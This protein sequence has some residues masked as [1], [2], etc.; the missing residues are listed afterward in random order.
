MGDR[1][2]KEPPES[3]LTVKGSDSMQHIYS[4]YMRN[5]LFFL[6]MKLS[7]SNSACDSKITKEIYLK[8]RCIEYVCHK[9]GLA[10]LIDSCY[11]R[12]IDYNKMYIIH[13]IFKNSIS[14]L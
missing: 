14:N 2:P 11:T 10:M 6:N 9:G 3:I 7:S 1:T 12:I 8:Q 5:C 4:H 13:H